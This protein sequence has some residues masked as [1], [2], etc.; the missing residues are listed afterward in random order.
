MR[1]SVLK[2]ILLVVV[3]LIQFSCSKKE[4]YHF[5][6]DT[7]DPKTAFG[8]DQIK[9]AINNNTAFSKN[10]TS[11]HFNFSIDNTLKSSESF[12]ITSMDNSIVVNGSDTNGLMYAALEI[13]EQIKLNN[14]ISKTSKTPYIKKRG[15]KYNIPLDAR[16]P[17]YDDSG[18]AAQ[19]N[20][21][22]MWEWPFWEKFID[23][24][25]INRYNTLTLWNPHPF[26]SMIKMPN[27]PDIALDDIYVTT[28][29]P[30]GQENE[31]A[32]PQMVSRN[33]IENLKKVKT[34]SI[35]EKISF[36]K[37]VMQHAKDRGIDIYYFNWNVCPNGAANPVE[38]FYRTY[39]QPMWDEK[40]GKYG[41]SNQM[42]NPI[43]ITYY[44]EAI[45]TFLLT[46]PNVKGIGVTAGEHMQDIG[47][48]YNRE[49]WIW[50]T[51]G[52]GMLDAKKEQPNRDV[53][54]IHRVWNTDMDKIMNYWKD[55]PGSFE[56][57]YKYAKA[58]LYSSPFLN[59]ADKHIEAMKP[60]N[61]KSWW[62]LRNDD[63]FVYRWGD[64]DY[65][66]SFIGHF[67]KEHTAGFYM[68]SDGY[69]W[70]KEFIS[71]QPE[72]SGKLEIDKHWFRFMLW[73]RLSYDNELDNNFFISKIKNHYPET[74]ASILF[75]SW[76]T[77]SKIIPEVNRFHWQNWDYQWAVE[78][79]IDAR[80]GFHTINHFMT[81]KTLVNSN[82]L[83]PMEYAQ[84]KSNNTLKNKTTPYNIANNLRDNA[85]KTIV[86]VEKLVKEDNTVEL[87]TLLDDLLAMAYLG[88]YYACKIEA[89]TELSL[90]KETKSEAYR[91]KGVKLLEEAVKHW[92]RYTEI[93]E[94]NYHPQML[95]RTKELDWR[96]RLESVKADI[97]IAK[98]MSLSKK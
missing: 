87:K 28:L 10:N 32:E 19:R 53:D 46:Y 82:I 47:G 86:G 91:A 35:D 92:T 6:G 97:D 36:W 12:S 34:I 78:A 66:R 65:V 30:I 72:L 90:M 24:M 11:I 95:A 42:D 68:G 21:A 60:Y 16:T 43:N 1:R 8:I 9:T 88:K 15:I 75:K 39:K 33:V 52:Q 38:P 4:G 48:D 51:Y 45:K 83:N 20:I 93:S 64:P 29:K 84:A 81:N 71:K 74:D 96:M 89:A 31:W 85:N 37:K 55:Y 2:S 62:N 5:E 26:P 61:L 69:V 79:C 70:G 17:S 7:Q 98:K 40:P 57:S 22:E 41:I 80:T 77:A 18:D 13:A 44:R 67:K 14:T 59:F 56:A 3:V 58:R 49:Q 54:F 23:N 25:A 63:I 76:Q 27:F 73:G 50:E 94:K